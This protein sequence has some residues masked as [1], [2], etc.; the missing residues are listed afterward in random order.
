MKNWARGEAGKAVIQKT[1]NYV[2]AAMAVYNLEVVLKK[3]A[4]W[5]ILK[6]LTF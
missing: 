3:E 1:A 2:N 4:K 5:S 6:Y